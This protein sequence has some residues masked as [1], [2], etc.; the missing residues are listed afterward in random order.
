MPEMLRLDLDDARGPRKDYELDVGGVLRQ[1][2]AVTLSNLPSF[3]LIGLIVYSPAL[4][5]YVLAAVAPI[6]A[7]LA[8]LVALLASLL[9]QLLTLVLTG[10]LAYGVINQLR[11]RPSSVG[12]T[13][14]VGLGSLGRVFL[15]SLLV[16]LMAAVGFVLCIV[17]GVIVV[18]M[19]WVAVPVAVVENP[20]VRA[21][22]DRSQQLTAGT[23]VGVFAVIL[24][25][26]MVSG[27]VGAVVTGALNSMATTL[28]DAKEVQ[29]P[30]FAVAQLLFT[31]L[32]LPFECLSAASAAVGYHDLR[33]H[34]EGA[35]VED[36]VRVFE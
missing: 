19:N 27:V 2:F 33:V 23:R 12:E 22:L 18:C 15:V 34:R 17:P 35:N 25:I 9:K 21:S 31:L 32:L 1:S 7:D 4:A 6:D 16:G 30:A 20:G 5:V 14:Q 13:V 8:T 11:G 29:G 3:L 36:L 28:T 24:V 26:G 10:A